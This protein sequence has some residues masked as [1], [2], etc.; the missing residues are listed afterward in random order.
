MAEKDKFYV[1][2]HEK[3]FK[4]KVKKPCN[5]QKTNEVIDI[6][7]K[8]RT[9]DFAALLSSEKYYVKKYHILEIS[10]I[11]KIIL[12]N[13]NGD[14]NIIYVTPIED[15]FDKIKEHKA[16]GHGRGIKSFII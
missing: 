7:K 8:C 4:T 12:K 16:T 11:S 2:L 9:E 1:R 6:L 3:Y 10:G 13:R 15:L 14:D 5:L